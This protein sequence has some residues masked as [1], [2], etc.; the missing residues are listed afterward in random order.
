MLKV[1][2]AWSHTLVLKTGKALSCALTLKVGKAWSHTQVLKTGKALSC[3]L[4]L[5][6]GKAWSHTLVLKTG[7]AL[8]CAQKLAKLGGLQK[9][10]HMETASESQ[11]TQVF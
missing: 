7:K 2:K 9:Q 4:T 11:H 1:G 3:A 10:A 5:K 8:S 6:V